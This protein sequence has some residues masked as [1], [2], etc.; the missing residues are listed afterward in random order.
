MNSTL[1]LPSLESVT[2]V[3]FPQSPAKL[4]I[5]QTPKN[6]EFLAYSVGDY[7]TLSA[8]MPDKFES[9]N[10]IQTQSNNSFYREYCEDCHRNCHEFLND[11]TDE[12]GGVDWDAIPNGHCGVYDDGYHGQSC[13]EGNEKEDENLSFDVANMVFEYKLSYLP[14]REYQRFHSCGDSAYLCKG[15]VDEEGN[16]WTTEILMAA[17]VF[18]GADDPQG[19]CW[20]SNPRPRSLR[21]IVESFGK[22]RFNNDLLPLYEFVENSNT[23]RLSTPDSENKSL[24][25]LTMG[26]VDA[27]A[28]LDVEKDLQAFFT[29]LMAGFNSLPEAPHIMMIPLNYGEVEVEGVVYQG[30][31]SIPDAVGRQWFITMDGNLLGQ[32]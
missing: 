14:S 7:L 20:G 6:A 10:Q 3:I 19:I 30:Y 2:S 22:T 32:V 9:V 4:N 24:K 25:L 28:L 12:F 15:D 21:G 23:T 5:H 18:G 17:N 8:W 26:G 1:E 29:F 13:P 16:I 31:K 11:Y 27:L